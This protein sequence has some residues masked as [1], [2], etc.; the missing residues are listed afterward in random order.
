MLG[1]VPMPSRQ[2]HGKA[3]SSSRL[4][5]HLLFGLFAI[6]TA[7]IGGVTWRFYVTQKEALERGVQTQLLTIADTKVREIAE[8]RKVRLGEARAI[9]A[10][11][12]TLAGVTARGRGEGDGYGT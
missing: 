4:A 6:L 10:D 3:L 11:T 8:S 5:P 12:F 9:M 7:A 1:Q 2:A